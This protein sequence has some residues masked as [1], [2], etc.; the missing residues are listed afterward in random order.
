MAWTKEE[1]TSQCGDI[2]GYVDKKE[3]R[4][5]GKSMKG[6]MW[7]E[8]KKQNRT[9]QRTTRSPLPNL[10]LDWANMRQE[11]RRRRWTTTTSVM[12]DHTSRNAQ[13]PLLS[14]YTNTHSLPLLMNLSSI[15]VRSVIT[16]RQM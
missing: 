6:C 15:I 13:H 10:H 14:C 1:T 11:E 12:V 4:E 9:E 16:K 8:K 2:L 7:P 5:Q 3:K